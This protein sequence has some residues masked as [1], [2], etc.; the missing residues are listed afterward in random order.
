[1]S[2]FGRISQVHCLD[3]DRE[4]SLRTPSSADL[5]YYVLSF[6]QFQRRRF[7]LDSSEHDSSEDAREQLLPDPSMTI[8]AYLDMIPNIRYRR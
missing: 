1:M 6:S 3:L 5:G 8:C 2:T 7:Y 4:G